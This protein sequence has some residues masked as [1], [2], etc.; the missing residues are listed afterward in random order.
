MEKLTVTLK[1]VTPL[2]LGGADGK[3]PEL[4][5]P[6]I[7]GAM[8]FWWRAIKG[9]DDIKKLHDE[10]NKIF[11]GTGEGE[12]RS[13]V[14]VRVIR[15]LNTMSGEGEGRSGVKEEEM[16]ERVNEEL[17]LPHK[18][19]WK[20]PAFKAGKEFKIEI[21]FT[22]DKEILTLEQF[23]NLF[24]LIVLLGGLGRRSR[25]GFG[26]LIITK[27]NDED[28]IPKYGLSDILHLLNSLNNNYKLDKDKIVLCRNA[29]AAYPFIGEIQ[30]GE[31]GVDKYETL[32]VRIGNAT[33]NIRKKY[34]AQ[35]NSLGFAGNNGRFASPV[36]VSTLLKSGR[37]Y[38]VITTLNTAF[39]N[40]ADKVNKNVQQDFIKALL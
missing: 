7:K 21:S 29:N 15:S 5:A 20:K 6:S 4:R 38:P 39:E 10:E 36:Y 28:Y 33:S 30:I 8:R 22:V 25:R 9:M 3:T 31:K 19:N 32:L 24:I 26:S 18:G 13:R 2:F 11:G 23:K 37:Y 40:K 1:T 12:G 17:I 34:K 27:I 35:A 16:F 14:I